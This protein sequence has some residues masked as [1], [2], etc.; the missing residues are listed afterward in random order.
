M[1]AEMIREAEPAGGLPRSG[2]AEYTIAEE[3]WRMQRSDGDETSSELE[4]LDPS[5]LT[6]E[7]RALRAAHERADAKVALARETARA[8]LITL[9]LLVLFPFA[10][11]ISLLFFGVKLGKRAFRVLYEPELRDRYLR[12]EVQRQVHTDVHSERRNLED[13]HHR[14][15]EQLS[16]SIAHEIRNPITAAKSLIQQMREDP[17]SEDRAEYARVAV[18]ELERVER[19]ISHLL[20]F[21]REEETRL[22]ALAMEDVLESAIETFRDR[23]ARSE[24]EISRQYDSPGH[25]E[26]DPEQLRRVVINLISNGLDA[27]EARGP[28]DPAIRVSMGENLAGSEVW[29]RIEDNGGGMDD[30]VRE[31]IFDPFFTS[32]EGGTGLGLALC[33]KMVDDH[34]GRIEVE[35]KTGEGTVFL[36][37]LPKRADDRAERS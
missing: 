36:V 13:E 22:S 14:T 23:A 26:G 35:S 10:G 28:A 4:N 11:V 15:L 25:L 30:N 16:A 18:S 17:E 8:G 2:M 24:I 33:R 12:E 34:R 9:P 29:I 3:G 27:I 1:W 21:G 5:L 19:S 6:E 32:R 20:R 37:T 7:E 31:Q